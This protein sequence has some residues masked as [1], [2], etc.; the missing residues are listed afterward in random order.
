MS[1][2]DFLGGKNRARLRQAE[3]VLRFI[4]R[5]VKGAANIAEVRKRFAEGALQ[6]D[7]D[8][9][10]SWA[11]ARDKRVDDFIEGRDG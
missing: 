4:E 2:F 7:L 11:L 1:I 6:G 8:G 9:V 3:I 5:V 10:I